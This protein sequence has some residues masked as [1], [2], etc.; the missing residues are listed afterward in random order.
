MSNQEEALIESAESI[1]EVED[2]LRQRKIEAI[3]QASETAEKDKT[4]HGSIYRSPPIRGTSDVKESDWGPDKV[5]LQLMESLPNGKDSFTLELPQVSEMD[6]KTHKF[7]RLL[8]YYGVEPDELAD[9]TGESLPLRPY[10]DYDNPGSIGIDI[11]Y[12]PVPTYPNMALYY[13][14]RSAER[15]GLLRWGHTPYLKRDIIGDVTGSKTRRSQSAEPLPESANTL[16]HPLPVLPEDTETVVPTSRGVFALISGMILVIYAL[17]TIAISIT[18]ATA[19]IALILTSLIIA[20][21]LLVIALHAGFVW[22]VK[23][24]VAFKKRFFPSIRD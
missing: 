21:P 23:G 6:D 16:V 11:D 22:T 15:L 2:E 4:E 8:A 17:F 24:L 9:I 10:G 1:V 3:K 13:A 19:T 5:E 20:I 7:N 12:P 18:S 14:R